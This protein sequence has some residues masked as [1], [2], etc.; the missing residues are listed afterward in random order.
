MILDA[1]GELA[2]V[3]NLTDHPITEADNYAELQALLI[4]L[5]RAQ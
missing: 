3:Y 5:A 1:E 2:A 4:E